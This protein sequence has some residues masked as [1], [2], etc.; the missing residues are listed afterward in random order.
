[1]TPKAAAAVAVTVW[2]EQEQGPE[3]QL[4]TSL[5]AAIVLQ[6]RVM[7]VRSE[8]FKKVK[9]TCEYERSVI[10]L[11]CSAGEPGNLVGAETLKVDSQTLRQML[12]SVL[13]LFEC[14]NQ[15]R[16]C[17]FRLLGAFH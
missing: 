9:G 16:A 2:M 13:S 12:I 1:V 8:N 17:L 4:L 15:L 11:S 14:N 3:C 10:T 7:N 5:P 6:N